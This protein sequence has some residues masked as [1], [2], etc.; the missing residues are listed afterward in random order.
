M[1]QEG[2]NGC[3][4]DILIGSKRWLCYGHQDLQNSIY[5]QHRNCNRFSTEPEGDPWAWSGWLISVLRTQGTAQIR[6]ATAQ[7]PRR[8]WTLVGQIVVWDYRGSDALRDRFWT[9][10]T[11]PRTCIFM[12]IPSWL[13]LCSECQGQ[14]DL[15]DGS[16]EGWRYRLARHRGRNRIGRIK[17]IVWYR[18]TP[19]RACKTLYG[20]EC[21][22]SRAWRLV[23]LD[24]FDIS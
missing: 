10:R 2:E 20:A 9:L 19:S 18:F 6:A 5:G 22:Q 15:L 21:V 16:L 12:G 13:P 7:V 24:A 3:R 23:W 14:S 17:I 4:Y 8:K 11:A 1:W